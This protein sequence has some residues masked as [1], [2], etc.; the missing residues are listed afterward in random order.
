MRVTLAMLFY[1]GLVFGTGFLLGPIRV[2]WLEPRFGPIIATACEAPFLLLAILIAARWVP[3][4][5]NIRRDSKAL[6]LIGVGSLVLLQIADFTIGFWLRGFTP[7]EQF[8]QLLTGQGSI[9]AALLALFAIMPW[10]ANCWL[11]RLKLRGHDR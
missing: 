11:G 8:V 6:V 4:V 5:L 1:F 3:R 9:Y 7:K 10:A 2:L